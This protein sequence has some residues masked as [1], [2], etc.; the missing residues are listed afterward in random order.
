MTTID[1]L[2]I[3]AQWNAGE[4]LTLESEPKNT[5]STWHSGDT[6][7]VGFMTLR[8]VRKLTTRECSSDPFP[9][10]L[11][12]MDGTIVYHFTPYRGLQRVDTIA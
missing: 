8:A 5:P 1:Y 11:E 7:K 10:E 6:V 3:A 2:A 9:W 12:S 4:T